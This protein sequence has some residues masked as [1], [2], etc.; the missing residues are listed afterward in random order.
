MKTILLVLLA[1]SYLNAF[2]Q[3]NKHQPK[4]IIRVTNENDFLLFKNSTDIFYTQGLKIEYL[5][6]LNDGSKFSKFWPFLLQNNTHN[7]IGFGLGQNI[8]TSSN[9]TIPSILENDRPYSSWLYLSCSSISNNDVSNKRLTTEFYFGVLGPLAFGEEVQ[10]N[11]HELINSPDPR[12]WH[13]QIKNDIGIN[14]FTNYEKGVFSCSTEHFSF[15][16][17]PNVSILTG[18]VF[19]IPA[20]GAT[21]RLSIWNSSTY[22][23]NA[24]GDVTIPKNNRSNMGISNKSKPSFWRSL[25]LSSFSLYINASGNFVIWNSLLQGG[26]LSQNSP[27]LIESHEINRIYLDLKYGITYSNPYFNLSYSRAFRTIEFSQQN[28]NHQWGRVQL[29]LIL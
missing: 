23:Q 18:T 7:T 24:H 2:P 6:K 29:E 12:G 5:I 19:N 3:T 20:L 17:V 10:S 22:F 27:Y 11:W 25:T 8:Y 15:D 14:L 9:I 1:A 16:F 4:A 28:Q 26:P 21:T 13:N